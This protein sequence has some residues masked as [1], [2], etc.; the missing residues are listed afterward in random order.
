MKLNET[1]SKFA[2]IRTAFHG[3]GTIAF[4]NSIDYAFRIAKRNT[5]TDCTCGCCDIVPVTREAAREL[6]DYYY[7]HFRDSYDLF[8]DEEMT[9]YKDYPT[10]KANGE[11]YSQL[12]R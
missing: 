4:T 10:Y 3:G 6:D 8:N 1:N 9:L 2:V 11:H 7:T 12:C 5:S